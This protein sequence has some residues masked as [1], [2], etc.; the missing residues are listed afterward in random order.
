MMTTGDL[1]LDAALR[2]NE[3][4]LILNGTMNKVLTK[5]NDIESNTRATL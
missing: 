2:L 4:I 5:L 1:K 3:N